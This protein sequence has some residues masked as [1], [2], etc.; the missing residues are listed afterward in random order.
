VNDKTRAIGAID[1]PDAFSAVQAQARGINTMNS[2]NIYKCPCGSGKEPQDCCFK[3]LSG[4]PKAPRF[5]LKN[6]DLQLN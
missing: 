2:D 4:P 1:A 3:D 5:P 6:Q